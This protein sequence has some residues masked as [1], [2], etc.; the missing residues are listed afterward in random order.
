MHQ[1]V[2]GLGS[3]KSIEAAL[4]QSGLI[5]DCHSEPLSLKYQCR[6][7]LSLVEIFAGLVLRSFV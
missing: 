2:T 5:I 4:N 6:I 7:F 1:V 3:L